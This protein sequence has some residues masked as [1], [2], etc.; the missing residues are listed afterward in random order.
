MSIKLFCEDCGKK[1]N[2]TNKNDKLVVS[3]CEC[4]DYAIWES[5]FDDGYKDVCDNDEE[6]T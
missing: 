6:V 3:R 1:L 2:F 5:G 4:E